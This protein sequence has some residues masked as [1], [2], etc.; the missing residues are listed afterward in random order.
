MT[1]LLLCHLEDD[2]HCPL[3]SLSG[4]SYDEICQHITYAH[5]EELSG[6]ARGPPNGQGRCSPPSTSTE[7]LTLSQQTVMNSITSEQHPAQHPPLSP[8][9]PPSAQAALNPEVLAGVNSTSPE[10]V[11]ET[12]LSCPICALVCSSSSILQEHVENHLQKEESG[13]RRFECPICSV[14]FSD[15]TSLQEH[16]ELHLD[17]GAALKHG[18]GS[19]SSDMLLANKL[20]D[21]EDEKRRQLDAQQEKDEFKKLQTQYGLNGR[22][23]YMRQTERSLEC[24]VAQ[25]IMTPAEFHCHRADMMEALSSGMDEG[26]TRT[27]GVV[28]AF[29]HYY[30]NGSRDHAHVWLSAD[31]DHYCS[32]A[33]DKGWGCGYRNLQILLSALLRMDTYRPFIPEQGIPSIPQLQRLIEEAWREGLDPQGAS[34][35]NQRLQGTRGWIGATEIYTFLTSLAIR[36]RI[37]DF[38]QPSGPGHT[39]PRLF[40]WVKQY[41]CGS[42]NRLPPAVTQT[43]LPPLYLQHQGHSRSIVGLEQK[44]SGALCLLLLDPGSSLSQTRK[45]LDAH[46][47]SSAMRH[48]RK[49]PKDLKQPQYQVVALQGTLS[50][51]EKERSVAESRMLRAERIP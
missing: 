25:G 48:V 8:R 34:H 14:V 23:G 51:E 26:R 9:R 38:H 46:T 13:G 24:A 10:S 18:P 32:S 17:E 20:Q 5:A 44:K 12:H 28:K 21:E 16:V 49:F 15:S 50:A 39:H 19:P 27:H 3:C 30:Q 22:G 43:S 6:A 42:S 36:A 40:E 4:V 1:H 2:L 47:I 37:V 7:G 45:L 11:T 31:A 29:H 35:F 33:G 41:F